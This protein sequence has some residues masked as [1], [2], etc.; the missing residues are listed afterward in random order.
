M[1]MWRWKIPLM[2]EHIRYSDHVPIRFLSFRWTEAESELTV[3]DK[4]MREWPM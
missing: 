2:P 3:S 4:Q 1:C